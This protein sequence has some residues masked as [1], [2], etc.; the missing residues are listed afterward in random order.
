MQYFWLIYESY[1]IFEKLRVRANENN[2]LNFLSHQCDQM[3]DQ[4]LAQIFQ[5]LPKRA[6]AIAVFT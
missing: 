5:K 2:F 4:K 6:T 1:F 3:V